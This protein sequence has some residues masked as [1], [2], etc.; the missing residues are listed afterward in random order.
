[1]SYSS[2]LNTNCCCYRHDSGSTSC[3]NSTKLHGKPKTR[4][5]LRNIMKHKHCDNVIVRYPVKDETSSNLTGRKL[6]NHSF[7]SLSGDTLNVC[8]KDEAES[9]C[10]DVICFYFYLVDH[11]L[12]MSYQGL[13]LQSLNF[14]F[15]LIRSLKLEKKHGNGI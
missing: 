5:S 3:F 15:Q 12:V 2:K 14:F 1:M 13:V 10:Q 9:M 4:R 11:W 7:E 8:L 6:A